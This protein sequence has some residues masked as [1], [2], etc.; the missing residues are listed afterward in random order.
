MD[1]FVEDK[2]FK[3]HNQALEKGEYLNCNFSNCDFSNLD[4]SHFLF[5]NCTFTDCNL[6]S[7]KLLNTSLQI[8]EFI[9]SKIMGVVFQN[10]NTFLLDISFD[11]C[12]LDFSSFY[13]LKLPKTNFLN[14][15]L[16]EVDFSNT[17]LI[18]S[19]FDNSF[20]RRSVFFNTDLRK[21]DFRLA[22]E[23]SL[24]PEHN[25]IKE[26]KF[27]RL[28]LASLLEKYEILIDN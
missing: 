19:S 21:V 7:V 8:V 13:D 9:N 20:L 10:V 6:S 11:N 12:I 18:G 24:D 4:F 26:A 27:N 16:N 5:D 2:D 22:K 1:V 28:D 14:S 15:T 25:K 23:F 17:V 3:N